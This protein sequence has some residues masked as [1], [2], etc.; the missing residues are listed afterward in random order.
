ML[1]K[2]KLVIVPNNSPENL[3]AINNLK[4][5]I[6]MMGDYRDKY[7][8]ELSI[9]KGARYNWFPLV[10]LHLYRKER[11]NI[12]KSKIIS[13]KSF[14]RK[15]FKDEKYLSFYID[16]CQSLNGGKDVIINYRANE[17]MTREIKIILQLYNLSFEDYGEISKIKE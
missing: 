16:G 4:Y 5:A 6:V 17:P 12:D 7:K 15:C 10:L 8:N 1:K 9:P 11:N 13:L 3:I 2:Y 14:F